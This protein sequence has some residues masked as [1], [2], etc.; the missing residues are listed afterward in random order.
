MYA[1]IKM[2]PLP[3]PQGVGMPLSLL[4]LRSIATAGF[5]RS[6]Q[7]QLHTSQS[8]DCNA[9]GLSEIRGKAAAKVKLNIHGNWLPVVHSQAPSG[10]QKLQRRAPK[11]GYTYKNV[12]CIDMDRSAEANTMK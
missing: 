5:G 9:A 11:D 3:Q 8:Q 12:L 10:W 1:L 6:D 4:R 2:L 7:G